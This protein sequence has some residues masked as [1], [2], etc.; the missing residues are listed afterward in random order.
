MKGFFI[1]GTDTGV[2]K[3]WMT[4]ALLRALAG[5]GYR[6]AGMKPLACGGHS[7]SEGWRHEDAE[8]LMQHA[9]VILPY[10]AVNPYLLREAVAPHIAAAQLGL[11]VSAAALHE[12]CTTLEEEMDCVLIEG[13]GG[14][15]VPLND[16][17]TTAHF[18]R[19]LGLPV[20]MVVGIRLGCLNHALL[21]GDAIARQK[22]PLA[23]WIANVIDPATHKIQENISALEA[24]LPGPRLGT[25]PHLAHFDASRIAAALFIGKLGQEF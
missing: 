18:A 17:E 16:E 9:N 4:A 10:E 24:R 1:T 25:V 19:L 14:W 13:V 12:A 5:H 20:I 22:L 21:T 7:T 11:R 23:G 15:E 6:V 3:T 2:G 8:L